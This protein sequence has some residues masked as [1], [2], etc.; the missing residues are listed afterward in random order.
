LSPDQTLLYVDDYRSHWVYSYRIQPDGALQ[1][2]QRYFWLHVPDNADDSGA[3]RYAH[4][5][6][7]AALRRHARRHTGLR[8]GRPCECH[9]SDAERQG[10]ESRVWREN[11][12]TL[13]ATCG[14]KIYKRK[15][16]V[17]GAHAWAAPLKPAA[18]RPVRRADQ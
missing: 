12:D 5:P 9:H 8:S 4:R 14:D 11:F 18:P 2:K 6:R 13:F 16:K 3:E 1:Y 10:L 17:K 7:R 15:V